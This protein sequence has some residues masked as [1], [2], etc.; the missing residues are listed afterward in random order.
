MGSQAQVR[1]A[2]AEVNA[3][4]ENIDV[5]VNNAAL[6]GCP[7]S[8]TPDG[9]ETQL[10][11]N[12]IGHFLFTNLILGKILAAGPGARVINVSSGGHRFSPIRWD[13]LNFSVCHYSMARDISTLTLFIGRY[14]V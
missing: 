7:Y 1:K 11:T 9:L 3:Y 10:G 6:M 2:A 12:H 4:G 14:Y 8:K 13:D 5:L